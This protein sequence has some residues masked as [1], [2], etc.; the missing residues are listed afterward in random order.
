MTVREK[1]NYLKPEKNEK[2]TDI[3]SL[4]R[5]RIKRKSLE[6]VIREIKKRKG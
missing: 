5:T 2:I 6:M 1:S 3:I 4:F